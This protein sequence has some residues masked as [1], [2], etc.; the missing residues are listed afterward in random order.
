MPIDKIEEILEGMNESS[1]KNEEI[2]FIINGNNNLLEDEELLKELDDLMEQDQMKTINNNYK[3]NMI[4]KKSDTAIYD[5]SLPK[6][7]QHPIL[8]S[9]PTTAIVIDITNETKNSQKVLS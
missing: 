6:V 3:N 5:S 7:P 2:N 8:P 4:E 1:E 9:V